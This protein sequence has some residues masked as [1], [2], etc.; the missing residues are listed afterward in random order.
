MRPW[1]SMLKIYETIHYLIGGVKMKRYISSIQFRLLA[2]ILCLILLVAASIAGLSAYTNINYIDS[3]TED[4][5]NE[6]LNGFT[7]LLQD[8]KKQSMSH[9]TTL[10][11]NPLLIEAT[12]S[13]NFQN[14]LTVTTSLMK[15]TDLDYMVITDQN[16]TVLIRTHEPGTIPNPSD[17]LADQE[18]VKQALNGTPF[19]GIEGGQDVKISILS[20]APIYDSTGALLGAISAGYNIGQ[21]TVVDRV[22]S[23]F[24]SDFSLFLGTEPVA[25]TFIDFSGERLLNNELFSENSLQEV[26]DSGSSDIV[27]GE[28][29]ESK[30]TS[31]YMPLVGAA[32]KNIGVVAASTSTE[33]GEKLKAESTRNIIIATIILLAIAGIVCFIIIRKLMRWLNNMQKLMYMAGQGDLTVQSRVDSTNEIGMLNSAFNIMVAH[34]SDIVEKFKDTAGSLTAASQELAATSEQVTSSIN[35][36]AGNAQ[37]V[38]AES[39]KGSQ[40]TI[41]AST[42]M[43]DLLSLTYTAKD[44]ANSTDESAKITLEA[45]K[46]GKNT[47]SKV[48]EMMSRIE[49]KTIE[50]EN[51]IDALNQY[52]H[53]I[54]TISETINTIAGQT[55]L[56]ALNAAIEAARA[57][58]AGKGFAVVAEEVRKLAEQSNQGAQEVSAL[59]K[60]VLES[61]AGAVAA[62]QESREVV[63]NGV[64]IVNKAGEA[65]QK[66]LYA[67]DNTANNVSSIVDIVDKETKS[68][69]RVIELVDTLSSV[70]ESTAHHARDVASSS[71]EITS[72]METVAASTEQTNATAAEL[73]KAIEVFNIKSELNLSDVEIL[74]KA[75]TDHIMWKL[76]ISNMLSGGEDVKPEDVTSYS[77]C[78]LGRWYFKEDNPFKKNRDYAALDK[79]HQKVHTC[80][81]EAA[82]AHKEGNKIKARMK[83]KELENYSDMAISKLCSLQKAASKK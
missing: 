43:K 41:E 35:E 9:A 51:M 55:N 34:Q 27:N 65:L 7:A 60:K 64:A 67:V 39:E 50:T 75:K 30:Y 31:G 57:G 63:E 33:A 19:V 80:V 18:N 20:G 48:V 3:T 69:D 62:T 17:S 73:Q 74:E 47:I 42:V 53:Q 82:V 78:R 71:S 2:G 15:N 8:Y 37:K 52:S 6:D 24:G 66:I 28:V 32:G 29:L 22:K 25:T 49:S 14:L 16:G 36:I 77:D 72:A 5:I 76:R 38:A 79:I 10:A 45:A 70:I 23:M 4:Q 1:I 56:L 54:D 44:H 81:Y 59:V 11:N 61:T 58:E 12:K 21:N 83:L 68:S 26:L 13:K 46:E 40:S